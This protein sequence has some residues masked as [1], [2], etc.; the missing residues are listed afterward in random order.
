LSPRGKERPKTGS[1]VLLQ[2]AI[3]LVCFL[4]SFLALFVVHLRVGAVTEITAEAVVTKP[5][6]VAI[7]STLIGP[8]GGS[9]MGEI[10]WSGLRPE[11]LEQLARALGEEATVGGF[12]MMRES[13]GGP[14]LQWVNYMGVT[15]E[16]F[17][18]MGLKLAAGRLPAAPGE[19]VLGS[20]VEGA[21]P[22]GPSGLYSHPRLLEGPLH[23]V[24]HLQPADGPVAPVLP[25][26]SMYQV[27]LVDSLVL[28]W[29]DV[30]EV[31]RSVGP[32]YPPSG[33]F[34]LLE[35][36]GGRSGAVVERARG[37]I[38]GWYPEAKIHVGV[39]STLRM[40]LSEV[41]GRFEVYQ[42]YVTAGFLLLVCVMVA[43]L[44]LYDVV[45]NW[46]AIAVRRCLGAARSDI[47][48][49]QARGPLAAS[50]VGA[51][52]GAAVCEFAG[53]SLCGALGLPWGTVNAW[54]GVLVSVLGLALL[55]TVVASLRAT[56]VPP[57]AGLSG[58]TLT[59][60][61]RRVDARKILAGAGAAI[62]VGCL[63]VVVSSGRSGM[64]YLES[65]LRAGGAQTAVVRSPLG[66]GEASSAAFALLSQ[67]LPSYE[68]ALQTVASCSIR[69]PGES[70]SVDASVYA[71][72]GPFLNIRG[73]E[74]SES[75]SSGEA[76]DRDWA[77]LGATLAAE[78]FGAADPLGSHVSVGGKDLIVTGV[79]GRRPDFLVDPVSD[80]DRSLI[81][82]F[83]SVADVPIFSV[84]T[85]APEVWIAVPHAVA[86]SEGLAAIGALLPAD[87][88]AEV[89]ALQTGFQALERTRRASN[90][91][92]L[93][94]A[95]SGLLVAALA[96]STCFIVLARERSRETAIRR[97]VGA[98]HLHVFRS[99]ISEAGVLGLVAGL[100]GA[101]AG[102]LLS[103]VACR[104]QAW[105]DPTYPEV[106]LLAVAASVLVTTLPTL[107]LVAGGLGRPLQEELRREE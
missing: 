42:S 71:V 31:T 97:A 87:L 75:L 28:T 88:G 79:L 21:I 7:Y 82:P 64:T 68:V 34:V 23:V 30:P 67:G 74:L 13:P 32:P 59:L 3:V 1:A 93:G 49:A 101:G 12:T 63:V 60:R 80:R 44:V 36:K 52:G 35:P 94:L 19:C 56:S 2:V 84:Q 81:V 78:L 33:L 43:S 45:R 29:R 14:G 106:L 65:L 18:I 37:L 100:G 40:V 24:G 50:V 89:E 61:R 54:L 39:G 86:M 102:W 16:Y 55:A 4:A 58:P 62:A 47:W 20:A 5:D 17:Q 26:A 10:T 27:K 15:P 104:S 53:P 25:G 66:D 85:G 107:P 105:P 95:I 51:V 72:K 91:L 76:P 22:T 9:G 99:A 103:L 41:K 11:E 83:E 48:A 92:L 90:A 6:N 77:Y 98:T 8:P 38:L 70:R 69:R 46:R 57:R 96:V 73:F